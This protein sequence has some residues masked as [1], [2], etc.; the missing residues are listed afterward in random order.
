MATLITGGTGFVGLNLAEHL[1]TTGEDVVLFDLRGL[2]P[3]V[4][5]FL[6]RLPGR[7][8]VIEGQVREGTALSRAL[9]SGSIDRV[10]HA[11]A[12]TA[13]PERERA[14]FSGVVDVNVMGTLDL[15]EAAH[16]AGVARVLVLSS[17]AVYGTGQAT[18]SELT[19][20]TPPAPASLYALTKLAAE[21]FALRYGAAVG[22]DVVAARVGAV[23]GR[24]E[25]S[26]GA[27]DTM[28]VPFQLAQRAMVGEEALL[29]KAVPKDWIYAPDVAEALHGLLV[30]KHPRFRLYNAGSGRVWR[31]EDCAMALRRAFPAFRFRIVDEAVGA[32]IS[33]HGSLVRPPMSIERLRRQTSFAPRFDVDAAFVNY[34]AWLREFPGLLECAPAH[35]G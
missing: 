2:A 18:D 21:Q 32:N 27:R 22:L 17:V 12:V 33:Y 7:L 11:A 25:H 24:W 26:S 20:E 13:G 31:I 5:A 3:R 16:R 30:C 10:V 28:S 15:L 14:Q 23:F 34:A 4:A 29:P 19:E 9:A 1:L 6:G 8:T 35:A